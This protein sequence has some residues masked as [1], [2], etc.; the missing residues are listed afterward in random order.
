MWGGRRKSRSAQSFGHYQD[1]EK[2]SPIRPCQRP[3]RPVHF[4]S[5]RGSHAGSILLCTYFD[6]V[7]ASCKQTKG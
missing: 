4:G 1:K 3:R 6:E 5:T 2:E 7:C